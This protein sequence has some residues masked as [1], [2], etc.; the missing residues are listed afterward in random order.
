MATL[1]EGPANRWADEGGRC[2]LEINRLPIAYL[3]LDA[4][5][6]IREWNSAAEGMLGYTRS[7]VLG[8]KCRNCSCRSRYRTTFERLCVGFEPEIQTRIA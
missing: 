5:L 4:D 3:F 8:K 7:E 6:N 2:G 1:G